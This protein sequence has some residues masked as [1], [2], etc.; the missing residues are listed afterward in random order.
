[1][2]GYL[3]Q[4]G[5]LLMSPHRAGAD[6]LPVLARARNM[7]DRRPD[8]H[9]ATESAMTAP[10]PAA[11]RDLFTRPAI[12]HLATLMPDGSPQVT[13]VW[14]DLDGEHVRV[15]SVKSRRKDRNIR[16]DAR[17]ALSLCD[18]D[19]PYRYL[20]LRGR[21]V[22]I[23]EQGAREHI[24][25]L[26]KKY[27]GVQVYPYHKDADVRVIYRIAPERFSQMG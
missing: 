20:E 22:A 21:V 8:A 15:N 19:N 25:A 11:Y 1:M 17:V 12:A 14:C 4:S 18:P 24:D 7:G 6:R 26:A 5:V 23:T 2:P 3:V 27:M 9:P 13:P 10:I 16:R